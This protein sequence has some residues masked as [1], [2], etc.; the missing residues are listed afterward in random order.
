MRYKVLSPV[1]IYYLSILVHFTAV[2]FLAF[3]YE[4]SITSNE[5][6]AGLILGTL[7]ILVFFW[8]LFCI[9]KFIFAKVDLPTNTLLFGNI[10]FKNEAPL[11]EV[12][13]VGKYLYFNRILKLKI[14]GKTYYLHC[15]EDGVAEF[16]RGQG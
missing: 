12:S 13:C 14:A 9:K 10:F 16:F 1:Y 3:L 5:H 11:R 4:K 8:F 15:L 2:V 7:S 6:E